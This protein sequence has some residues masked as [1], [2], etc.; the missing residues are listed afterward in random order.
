VRTTAGS[1]TLDDR[2]LA[3]APLGFSERQ[4]RFLVT[5]AVHSG[6]CLRR[7]YSAFSGVKHGQGVRDFFD[8]LVRRRLARRVQMRRDR[9]WV[10]HLH[11]TSL[12]RA[13]GQGDNRNR[14]HTSPALIARKLML[15]DFVLSRPEW[16]WYATEQD[17]VAVFT[18]RFG[19]PQLVLPHRVYYRR[20]PGSRRSSTRRYFIQKLPIALGGDDAVVHFVFLAV[21]FSAQA[22][23]H[24]VHDHAPLLARLPAWRIVL[25]SSRRSNAIPVCEAAWRR[26]LAA[27]AS[28]RHTDESQL[29]A[30]MRVREAIEQ[31]DFR[32]VSAQEMMAF[33]D[34]GGRVSV[35]ALEDL[36]V[37]WQER[38][39][40]AFDYHPTAALRRAVSLEL[41]GLETHQLPFNYDRFGSFPGVA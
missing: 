13:I 14:R 19:A 28:S 34:I 16:T 21:D 1:M 37:R 20:R 7:H 26:M 3:L 40:A 23:I 18:S 5:V 39:D 27:G 12:Y 17:K 10:Y 35:A 11:A 29:R 30:C 32:R 24:F 38:G 9:G 6:F 8:R 41:G 4:T 36:F 15:L 33:N 2:V 22:F 31:D 25:V